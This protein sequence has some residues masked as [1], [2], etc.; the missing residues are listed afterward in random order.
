M[1]TETYRDKDKRMSGSGRH[2]KVVG[3][4]RRASDSAVIK[5]LCSPC[6]PDGRII[7]DRSTKISPATLEKRFERVEI[8]T[9]FEGK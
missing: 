2:V 5:A 6:R 3:L 8:P 7:S 4:I 1:I 9:N